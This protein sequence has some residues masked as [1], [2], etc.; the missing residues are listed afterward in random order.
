MPDYAVLGPQ[1]PQARAAAAAA[2][3]ELLNPYCGLPLCV[4]WSDD[5]DHCVE[6]IEARAGGW[7]ER[8][9]VENQGDKSHRAACSGCALRG[10]CGGAWHA[11]W[12]HRDGSGIAPPSL[13]IAPWRT[14]AQ[15]HPYQTIVR[16][17]EGP[18]E[19]SWVAIDAA[20]TPTVWLWTRSLLPTDLD[21]LKAARCTDVGLEVAAAGMATGGGEARAVARLLRRL[22]R[23]P[24]RVRLAV[25]PGGHSRDDL[26]ALAT[27]AATLGATGV[28]VL[29]S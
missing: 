4:G 12:D 11:Y 20:R 10:W 8:P 28:D 3:I 18:T 29:P 17:P 19:A 22:V 14:G 25:R 23:G 16:A 21:R 13:T 15:Q 24:Q 6:A 27:L 2:G 26:R 1:V 7:Q 5:L 9:G